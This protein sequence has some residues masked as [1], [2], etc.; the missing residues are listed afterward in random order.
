MSTAQYFSLGPAATQF[1]VQA[2]GSCLLA[3]G[4]PQPMNTIKA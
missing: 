3:G 1:S 4:G 2:E